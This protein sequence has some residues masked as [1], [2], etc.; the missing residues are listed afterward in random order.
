MKTGQK[1]QGSFGSTPNPPTRPT[2]SNTF[3]SSAQ[4]NAPNPPTPKTRSGWDQFQEQPNRNFPGMSRSNTTRTPRKGGFA[5]STPGGDEPQARNTSAYANVT[6]RER[7][8]APN[9]QAPR[10]H[11]QYPPPPPGPPPTIK[12]PD[13]QRP[14]PLRPFRSPLSTEDIFSTSERL[15]TP[16]AK[17][18]G[19]KT[20]FSSGELNRTAS[21]HSNAPN[22][23]GRPGGLTPNGRSPRSP[24]VPGRHHSASPKMRSPGP[25]RSYSSSSSSGSSD[26]DEPV[27][28]SRQYH[29]STRRASADHRYSAPPNNGFRRSEQLASANT[30]DGD[31]HSTEGSKSHF[32]SSW[33][34]NDTNG[35]HAVPRQYPASQPSSRKGSSGSEQGEGF[36]Q[37]RMRQNAERAQQLPRSPLHATPPMT[38]QNIQK[39][40]EKSHSWDE[41]NGTRDNGNSQTQPGRHVPS[42]SK[43]SRPMYDTSEYNSSPTTPP[44]SYDYSSDKNLPQEQTKPKIPTSWPY[45]A[46]PSSVMPMAQD[47]AP[48]KRK[49]SSNWT[50]ENVFAMVNE[51]NHTSSN[52][53]H[54]PNDASGTNFPIKSSRSHENINTNFSPSDWH[55]KFSGEPGD[56]LSSK[57]NGNRGRGRSSPTK[58]R[59]YPQTPFRERIN[60]NIP[61][62]ID[63]KERSKQMPPPPTVPNRPSSPAQVKFSEEEWRQQFREP[64]WA[65]PPPPPPA[66]SPRIGSMK[67]SKTPRAL[68]GTTKRQTVPKPA[69]V[70][71]TVDD[72]GDEE[73]FSNGPESVIESEVS[74]GNGSA[75]DIDPTS[76]PPTAFG[77]RTRSDADPVVHEDP[78]QNI[79]RSSVP[80]QA[81]EKN[82]T[83]TGS[84]HLNLN[85][86]KNTAPF[87]PS[88]SGLKDLHDLNST[89]PFE[90]GP[91]AIPGQSTTARQLALPNPPK[92][93]FIPETLTQ[94]SWDYYMAYMRAYMVEWSVF[95]TKM[96][97]HFSSRQLEVETKLGKD[98]MSSVGGEGYARYMRGVDE[99]FRVRAHWEVGWE[100]HRECM[101]SLGKVREKAVRGQFSPC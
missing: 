82:T 8:Q 2:R 49:A 21:N 74:S 100:K 44:S 87:A 90:S 61:D 30:D 63:Q 38:Y 12:R 69:S 92:A 70:S 27:I 25:R 13:Q 52:R 35:P 93:P 31:R 22:S 99:D 16:Y 23:G 86:L 68:S 71:A 58:A 15:S 33:N 84:S 47:E 62:G 11:S 60:I 77:P 10:P 75:M 29:G 50:K 64:N 55:G 51:A 66:Q 101:R 24:G 98:W 73:V 36:L 9:T 19:E 72:A 54:F 46:I 1:A 81:N 26:E 94:S 79:I 14:D 40:L 4:K 34:T 88:N 7:A 6:A 57:E 20:Y 83:D 59:P 28:R 41:K 3:Q 17:S 85:D 96:V 97:S 48:K 89:L 5:P 67:R 65:Y 43:D 95:N 42:D 78:I 39:P 91:S 80:P 32:R 56:F 76:T 18:G 53:F 37:H 45:W